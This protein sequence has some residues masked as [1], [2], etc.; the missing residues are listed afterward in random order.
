M[1]DNLWEVTGNTDGFPFHVVVEQ[2]GTR[3]QVKSME[4]DAIWLKPYL[5]K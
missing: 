1:R 4:V 5:P 3:W 2:Q